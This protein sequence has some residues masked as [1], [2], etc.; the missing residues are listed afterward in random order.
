MVR[1]NRILA[2]L[3]AFFFGF[4]GLDRFYLGKIKT[5]ILKIITLGGFGIWWFI[6]ATLLLLD[7]FLYSLG[8]DHGFVKDKLG[9]DLKYGLSAYRFKAG[10][11]HKDWFADDL[12]TADKEPTVSHGDVQSQTVPKNWLGRNWKWVIPFTFA[13]LIAAVF[14]GIMSMMKSSEVYIV[15]MAAV[16][17][18][19]RITSL[20]GTDISDAFFV[21][22]EFSG[23]AASMKIPVSG[24]KGKGNVYVQA[25]NTTGHWEYL[26]LTLH[27]ESEDIDLLTKE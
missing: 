21:S 14:I 3:L 16:K 24:S 27:T 15:S 25:T 2:M 4:L 20:L 8:K 26:I 18:D 1:K 19:T 5:G 17:N 12:N 7:A 6:D 22:G 11:F 23:S 10:A 9:Q 13:S